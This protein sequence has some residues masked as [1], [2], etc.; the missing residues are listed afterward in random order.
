V[1]SQVDMKMAIKA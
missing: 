1:Y